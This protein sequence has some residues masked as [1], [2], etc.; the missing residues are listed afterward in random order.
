MCPIRFFNYSV[1]SSP[2]KHPGSQNSLLCSLNLWH[3]QLK[4]GLIVFVELPFGILLC[5][6]VH[7]RAWMEF[8]EN[9]VVGKYSLMSSFFLFLLVAG[10][11][12]A[13]PLHC[14]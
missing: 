9:V 8:V 7:S 1:F 5:F 10:D 6:L 13:M 14:C 2:K 4:A 3:F 11:G 12:C